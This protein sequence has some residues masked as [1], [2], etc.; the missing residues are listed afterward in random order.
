[1]N[2]MSATPAR[3]TLTSGAGGAFI[4]VVGAFNGCVSDD[5]ARS[6]RSGL[7]GGSGSAPGSV[8]SAD[9]AMHR[10]LDDARDIGA[11]ATVKCTFCPYRGAIAPWEAMCAQPLIRVGILSF[12]RSLRPL[13]AGSGRVSPSPARHC[14]WPAAAAAQAELPAG[15]H[16]AQP[17]S[18]RMACAPSRPH[19]K[20]ACLPVE[21]RVPPRLSPPSAAFSPRNSSWHLPLLGRSIR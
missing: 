1:M 12:R 19:L 7:S 9:A 10:N 6:P 3:V 15:Q 8:R 16:R 20:L 11:V 5:Q 21:M 17:S 13:L 2:S 4:A 14:W 18:T